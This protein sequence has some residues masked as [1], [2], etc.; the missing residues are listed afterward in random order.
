MDSTFFGTTLL[1]VAVWAARVAQAALLQDQQQHQGSS[2]LR[3]VNA[4]LQEEPSK[5]WL[6][7]LTN[8]GRR[9]AHGTMEYSKRHELFKQR[10][11]MIQAHNSKPER[12][13]TA[14]ISSL[15]DRT[16]REL[17][18]LRGWR[19]VKKVDEGD[20]P[21][22]TALLAESA[23]RLKPP[24]DEVDWKHLVMALQVPDQGEC[25]SCW[26][27]ATSSMLQG[28][29]EARGSTAAGVNRSF[30]IQELVDC[31]PNPRECGGSGG[32]NGAT[33]ELALQYVLEKGLSDAS[34]KPYMGRR[35]GKVGC[36]ALEDV[37][38]ATKQGTSFLSLAA[39]LGDGMAVASRGGAGVG[40]KQWYK[41]PENQALPLMRAV[42]EGPVAISV[43]ASSWYLYTRGIYDSCDKDAV[44][45]HA[46]TLFG[47][48][49]ILDPQKKKKKFWTIRNS[50]GKDWGESG[51]IRLLRHDTPEAD[52]QYCGTDN[53]PKEGVSCKPYP[54]SVKVCGMCGLLY[55]SAVAE[56]M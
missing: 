23:V 17:A 52:S 7:F 6:D 49:H 8:F 12:L 35:A 27:V 41:L 29:Y 42:M 19:R 25:G 13:W 14:G 55:D 16:E 53:D 32:C 31:V 34:S 28:R 30:S 44:I 54:D 15:T 10:L 11:S 56:F 26:A 3:G 50:W 37:G 51:F 33:V 46:V 38:E 24:S 9:Y 39:N 4:S 43:A 20:D 47:Y 5:E 2:R 45:D 40:L 48:G 18:Q 22:F 36:A 21:G 1:F